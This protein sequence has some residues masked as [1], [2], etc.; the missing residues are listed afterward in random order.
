MKL[1]EAQR[2]AARRIA[3]RRL[4]RAHP[5]MLRELRQY[6]GR[7]QYRDEWGDHFNARR[8]E[9]VRAEI[10]AAYPEQ[11]RAFLKEEEENVRTKS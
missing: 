8:T 3:G 9:Q 6:Y 11:Y 2:S 1:T 4:E 7:Q 10:Q 5:F